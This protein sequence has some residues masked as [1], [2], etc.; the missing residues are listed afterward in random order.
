MDGPANSNEE[1]MVYSSRAIDDCLQEVLEYLFD[2]KQALFPDHIEG[3]VVLR[4]AYQD[5]WMLRRT[6]N[7][8]LIKMKVEK[9]DSNVV[10]R[11][12]SVEKAK[13][14]WPSCPMRQHY[15]EMS[16]LVKP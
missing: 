13:V 8:W 2:E 1:G 14:T 16:P 9:E 6:S 12:K 15:A 11:W 3:K 10:N 4:K 7:T 5:F